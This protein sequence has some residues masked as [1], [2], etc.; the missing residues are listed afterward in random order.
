MRINGSLQDKIVGDLCALGL[1][2]QSQ[3]NDPSELTLL[4]EDLRLF[5]PFISKF[6]FRLVP[7]ERRGCPIQFCTGLIQPP[8]D[9]AASPG[10]LYRPI[11]AGGQGT[12][13]KKASLSCIGELAE[14]VSLC[15]QGAGDTRVKITSQKQSLVEIGRLLGFSKQQWKA[16]LAVEGEAAENATAGVSDDAVMT[17]RQVEVVRLGGGERKLLPAIAFLFGEATSDGA[18]G[19]GLASSV[20]C[21]VWQDVQGARER[22]LLELVERDVVAQAWYNRLGITRLHFT[23]IRPVLPKM[24]VE[25]LDEQPRSWGVYHVDTDLPVHVVFAVSYGDGGYQAAFGASAGWNLESACFSAVSELLQSENSLSLMEQAYR[26]QEA[27]T[28]RS[29]PLPTHLAYA[30]TSSILEDLPLKRVPQADPKGLADEFC[31]NQLLRACQ[32]K[33]MEIWEFEATRSDLNIPCIKLLSKDLCSWEP[34]FGKER[35]YQGVVDRGLR[36]TPGTEAEFA[37]RPFPF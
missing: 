2:S 32:E 3:E 23:Q 18:V 20:G 28:G 16:R 17:L 25:F 7:L 26:R 34:R 11:P 37:A 30:R 12:T 29:G 6:E 1:L 24:L 19:Q 4:S 8:A 36:K 5:L 33:G 31:Y 22:A 35:L 15:S 13:L 27:E 14:R 21:A 10:G 9:G